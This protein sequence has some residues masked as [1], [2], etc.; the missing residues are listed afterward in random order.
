MKVAWLDVSMI[1]KAP[2]A[3]ATIRIV[4]IQVTSGRARI[5]RRKAAAI[6]S[7]TE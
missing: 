2:A 1:E 5:N 3:I 6:S 4:P 7:V